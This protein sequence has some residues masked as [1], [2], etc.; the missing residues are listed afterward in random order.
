MAATMFFVAALNAFN[1][2][3]MRS[4]GHNFAATMYIIAAVVVCWA[5][6]QWI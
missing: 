6:F 2:L 1:A 5:G 3:L 4:Y